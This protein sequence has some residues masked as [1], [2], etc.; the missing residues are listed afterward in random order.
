MKDCDNLNHVNISNYEFLNPTTVIPL[1]C[2]FKK[3]GIKKIITHTNIHE[4]IQRILNKQSIDTNIPYTTLPYS[5][6]ESQNRELGH[7]IAKIINDNDYGGFFVLRHILVELINNIYN[8]TPFEEKLASQGHIYAQKHT[9]SEKLDICVMDDGVSIPGR[10][11]KSG[12]DFDNSCHAIEMAISNNSTKSNDRLKRGNG[13]WS[14]LKLVVEGNGGSALIVSGGACL[15]IESPKKYK[16]MELDNNN[17][18][19]GTLISVRLNKNQVQNIHDLIFIFQNN[20][21]KY[22]R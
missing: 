17:I 1:L 12:M 14:T 20:P 21:Y 6:K 15:H 13:L 22:N 5:E 2:E 18:F 3:R 19:K 16:Y 8:H 11:K 7:T 4:D 9:S 10:F